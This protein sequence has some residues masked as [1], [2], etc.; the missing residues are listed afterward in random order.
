MTK[1]DKKGE[2]GYYLMLIASVAWTLPI[3][4][5]IAISFLLKETIKE[6]YIN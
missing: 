4:G 3:I 6:L 5:L 2:Y 1:E